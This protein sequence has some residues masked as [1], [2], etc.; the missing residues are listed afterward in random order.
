MD[1]IDYVLWINMQK[2]TK[3][4]QRMERM[5]SKYNVPNIRIE[6]VD[7]NVENTRELISPSIQDTDNLSA[8]CCL[9]HIKALSKIKDLPGEYFLILEDDATDENFHFFKNI[10]LREII[11]GCPEFDLLFLHKMSNPL[12][13]K[14]YTKRWEFVYLW[15]TTAYVVAKKNIGNVYK[16]FDHKDG[17]FI[18][19]VPRIYASDHILHDYLN[20]YVYKYN[21][22]DILCEDSEIHPDHVP[23]HINHK[24]ADKA[25]FEQDFNPI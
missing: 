7:G 2:S 18:I 20:T 22:F 24:L 8:G 1:G 21:Y 17:K 10:N 16:H 11:K 5:L 6:G 15:S 9:S 14:L 13:S 4:R 19:N 12:P 25:L 23:S 3:R